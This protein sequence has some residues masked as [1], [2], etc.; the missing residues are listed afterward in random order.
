MRLRPPLR[1]QVLYEVHHMESE[2]HDYDDRRDHYDGRFDLNVAGNDD[3]ESVHVHDLVRNN[4]DC[5][6]CDHVD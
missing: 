4:Y 3:Y 1:P 6:V 2:R 5:G